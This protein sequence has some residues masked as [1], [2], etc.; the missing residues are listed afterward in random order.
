MRRVQRGGLGALFAL[1]G[2]I[3][4]LVAAGGVTL[5]YGHIELEAVGAGTPLL[6]TVKGGESLE[7]LS[8]SLQSQGLIKSAFFF[9]AYARLRGVHLRAGEYQLDSGMAA[10]EMINVLEAPP[11]CPGV[12]FVIPEGFTVNQIASRVAATKGLGITRQEYLDA[13]TAGGYDAPFLAIRPA[14]DTSLEGFLFP[15]T[16]TVP[17]CAS[18][19]QVVQQQL[20]AFAANV[21]PLLPQSAPQA[22][23]DLI[24][25]SLVEAEALPP[26]YATVASVIDNRLAIDMRLQIDSSVMYGLQE[27]GAAMSP[28]DEATDTPY[29]TY[30]NPG[31]PPTPIDNPGT[32]AVKGVLAP[33]STAYLFYVTDPCGVAHFSVTEAQHEQQVSQYGNSC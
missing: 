29:N 6:V 9:S 27:S 2:A 32:A 26:D 19:H 14:G 18:A 20:D 22:Y 33:A 1:V 23:A 30:I 24:S 17:D 11:F 8:D 13:V 21:V 4:I 10:S 25:A 15:A 12:T 28:A 3:V 31:L 16:Y 5:L 7:Q